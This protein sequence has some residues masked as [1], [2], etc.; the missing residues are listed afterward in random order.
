MK[1]CKIFF[2]VFEIITEA[3]RHYERGNEYL[4]GEFSPELIMIKSDEFSAETPTN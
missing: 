3:L 1:F 4:T 2:Y